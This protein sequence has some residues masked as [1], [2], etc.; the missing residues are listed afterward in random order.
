MDMDVEQLTRLRKKPAPFA[1][2]CCEPQGASSPEKTAQILAEKIRSLIEP[3]EK[4]VF[5]SGNFNVV[6][7]GHLR[8][9]NFARSCGDFLV[10]GV[11]DDRQ[12]GVYIE[13]QLRLEGVRAIG[14]V[15][16][17]IL[18]PVSAE[19]FISLL[20]PDVVV[21][22]KEH[23]SEVNPE[24][25]AMQPYGGKLLFAS[26]ETQFSSLDLLQRELKVFDTVPI[27]KPTGYLKRHQID[28]EKLKSVVQKFE[29]LKVAV[30]G[31]LIVDEY[32]S[33]EA[34]G[35]SQEDPTLV[36]TPFQRDFFIGGAGIVAAH[37]RQ[38]GAD[39]EY[40]SVA[41]SDRSL[42]YAKKT[43]NQ[44]GVR[45]ELLIDESRPTTLKQRFRAQ[46][47]T[48]LRVSHLRQHDL[49]RELTLVLFEKIKER[50]QDMDLVVFS[51]FNYGCLTQTLIEKTI[52]FC[53]QKKIPMVA[54]S[55]SS[56]QLGDIARFQDMLLIT[57]TEREAR[58]SL[59]ETQSSL[60]ALAEALRQKTNARYVMVTL[61]AEGSLVHSHEAISAGMGTDQLPALNA[62]PKDPSGAGDC[63]FIAASMALVAG[64]NI[65]ESAYLGAIA[66]AC[67]V[68]RLG[69][70]P[71]SA[72]ELI[73]EL[74]V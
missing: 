62:A 69:N 70:L 63:L 68:G 3:N 10:V 46:G 22:G 5:V 23:Q 8:V 72:S 28:A 33:C 18:L 15:D 32:V 27:Q 17:A 55:Q 66:A 45:A 4:I 41:G 20:K 67:Q 49:S 39:V 19:A 25:F 12:S 73:Q 31:D 59:R 58:L 29:T 56:S 51:D 1:Q 71:L 34:L 38:L 52:A 65:W 30:M 7:P 44:Y 36:V 40:F 61:G 60:V 74:A 53:K 9:L 24:F 57:P 6:H 21:K 50:L 11:T 48:L 54:D 64:A 37:A 43:L 26:G 14:S 42:D 47:K 13:E 35:M 16:A 2:V